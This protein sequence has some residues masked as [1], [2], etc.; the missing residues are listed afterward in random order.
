MIHTAFYILG[1]FDTNP[2]HLLTGQRKSAPHA[3]TNLNVISIQNCMKRD[4]AAGHHLALHGRYG[5]HMDTDRKVR[6]K[7]DLTFV[8]P[9]FKDE[10]IAE[11]SHLIMQ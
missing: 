1:G 9:F 4:N 3:A 2:R 10:T 5:Y 7:K 6:V 8:D 11:M